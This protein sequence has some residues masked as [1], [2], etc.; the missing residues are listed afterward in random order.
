MKIVIYCECLPTIRIQLTPAHANQLIL[1]Q[2]RAVA[3]V[4]AIMAAMVTKVAVQAPCVDS[5]LRAMDI[6]NIV[7]PA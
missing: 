7:E 5:E 4:N 1:P 3:K 2:V 6:L